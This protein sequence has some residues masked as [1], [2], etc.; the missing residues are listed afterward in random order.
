MS[1]LALTFL[2]PGSV[3]KANFV[4]QTQ[5]EVR[6]KELIKEILKKTQLNTALPELA[7]FRLLKISQLPS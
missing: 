2:M 3:I 1:K 4:S 7:V 5:G 6:Q